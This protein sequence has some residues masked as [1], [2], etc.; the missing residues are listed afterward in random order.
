MSGQVFQALI[1][2]VKKWVT[3]KQ[4]SAGAG[5]AGSIVALNSAGQIDITMFPGGLAN[6]IIAVCSE[7]LPAGCPVNLYDAAGTPKLRKAD[8]TSSGKRCHGF[9]QQAFTSGD[10]ATA[11]RDGE[12]TGLTGLTS[13][14]EYYLSTTA[15]GLALV[16]A[17][18]GYTTAGMLIQHLGTAHGTTILSLAID[19]D[20]AQ[21][22]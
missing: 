13:G 17:V 7:D 2:G 19:E 15:G 9:T 1:S 10:T 12:I 11:F 21:I 18:A 5:D 20:P 4:T 14:A 16:A 8:A 22:A 3:S 6:Q